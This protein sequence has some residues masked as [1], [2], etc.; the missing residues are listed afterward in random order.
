MFAASVAAA[1]SGAIVDAV[2]PVA[3]AV[4]ALPGAAVHLQASGAGTYGF[5]ACAGMCGYCSM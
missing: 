2:L 1:T 5:G 4:A 3:S